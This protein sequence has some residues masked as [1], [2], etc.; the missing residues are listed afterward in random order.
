MPVDPVTAT[1]AGIT[2]SIKI[3]EVTYL[4]KAVDEQTKDLLKTTKLVSSNVNEARRLR[5]QKE[6][7]LNSGD[8][9]WMDGI[10]AA[11]EEA[12]VEVQKLG[13]PVR[14][15]TETTQ[16]IN[17]KNRVLWVFRDSP[18]VRDKHNHLSSCHQALIGVIT[19]LHS[20][21]VVVV[22]PLPASR[23][24]VPPPPYTA[25]YQALFKWRDQRR[26]KSSTNM[27]ETASI[28]S[29][30]LPDTRVPNLSVQTPTGQS[31]PP[32]PSPSPPGP[33]SAFPTQNPMT[34]KAV[35]SLFYASLD[36]SD[37][38]QV[39]QSQDD[40]FNSASPPPGWTS[41]SFQEP[42]PQHAATVPD[43]GAPI[44]LTRKSQFKYQRARQAPLMHNLK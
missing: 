5:Q 21:D 8:R 6:A 38:L 14:V 1:A 42:A 4:L 2:S 35:P 11:T 34:A 41:V 28:R 7:L 13:E 20:K 40:Y 18:K 17:L 9:D 31:S 15:S 24:E 30:P 27:R 22:A 37:G 3:L 12:L 10:I 43:Y 33:T 36:G 16:S 44:R 26:R 25:D 32:L 39:Q 29:A 19:T 23:T